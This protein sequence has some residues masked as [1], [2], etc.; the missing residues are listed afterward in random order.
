MLS[1][2]ILES[3]AEIVSRIM[4]SYASVINDRFRARRNNILSA[5]RP[6]ISS[7]LASSPEIQSL[8]GGT[9]KADFGLTSDPTSQII[10][11]IVSTIDV[12]IQRVRSSGANISGG[13]R[14]TVQP[15]DHSNLLSLPIA[16]QAIRGGSLPWLKW[17]LTLGDT[18]IIADFGVEYGPH[19]R[20]GGGR[21]VSGNRPFKVNSAFSGTA[22][23]NFITRAMA[24]N[25]TLIE[26]AIIGAI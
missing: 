5:L 4:E 15:S 17:L 14:I 11:S 25:K 13:L 21:M 24:R 12:Q 26:D 23:D 6:V 10:S 7:A 2:N 16:T 19:G 18:I 22:D 8:S 3:D 9:L 20:S 1:I